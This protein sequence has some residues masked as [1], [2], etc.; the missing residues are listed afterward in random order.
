MEEW[1][2]EGMGLLGA[3]VN[4]GDAG[5]DSGEDGPGDG[6]GLAGEFGDEDVFAKEFGFIAA[7]AVGDGGDIHHDL[8]HGDAA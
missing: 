4:T 8:I 5:S 2:N 1:R 7:L 3:G 6:V